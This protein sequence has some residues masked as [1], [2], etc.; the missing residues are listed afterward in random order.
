[1]SQTPMF[2]RF[3]EG[4]LEPYSSGQSLDALGAR[5]HPTPFLDLDTAALHRRA[6]VTRNAALAAAMAQAGRELRALFR[7]LD[8]I[9]PLVARFRAWRERERAADELF[10]LDDRTLAE[11]GIIRADIPFVAAGGAPVRDRSPAEQALPQAANGND[12]TKHAA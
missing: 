1:M 12:D 4:F 10:A 5:I 6:A 11:L 2:N 7:A 9:K 3:A 8:P